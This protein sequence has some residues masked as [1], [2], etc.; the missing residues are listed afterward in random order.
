[1]PIQ[2]QPA[3]FYE[4]SIDT[5]VKGGFDQLVDEGRF[6]RRNGSLILAQVI[7]QPLLEYEDDPEQLS[8]K[9]GEYRHSVQPD[10][11]FYEDVVVAEVTFGENAIGANYANNPE[12]MTGKNIQKVFGSWF[13]LSDYDQVLVDHPETVDRFNLIQYPGAVVRNI[14]PLIPGET[15]EQVA[16]IGSYTGSWWT[17]DQYFAVASLSGYRTDLSELVAGRQTS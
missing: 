4:A 8:G 3:E 16:A 2:D 12:T 13:H 10:Q 5:F 14:A 7:P 11:S 6:D 9:L 1:M 15:V 17:Y